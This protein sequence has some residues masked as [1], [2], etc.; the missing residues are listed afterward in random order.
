MAR[1]FVCLLILPAAQVTENYVSHCYHYILVRYHCSSRRDVPSLVD[2][3]KRDIIICYLDVI[4]FV[5][6]ELRGKIL[7]RTKRLCTSGNDIVAKE[8]VLILKV[9]LCKGDII[10]GVGACS[11]IHLR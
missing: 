4:L 3:E 11:I 10:G 9:Q 1:K 5:D 6:T 7:Y 2:S 8:I